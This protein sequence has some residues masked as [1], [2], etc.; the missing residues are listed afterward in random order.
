[1][2]DEEYLQTEEKGIVFALEED[3]VGRYGENFSVDVGN[4]GNIVLQMVN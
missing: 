4:E 1:M 3:L 2:L